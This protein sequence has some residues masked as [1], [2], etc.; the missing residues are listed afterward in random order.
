MPRGENHREVPAHEQEDDNPTQVE[1]DLNAEQLSKADSVAHARCYCTGHAADW[2]DRR[3]A[4][5]MLINSVMRLD[6]DD[7]DR[8]FLRAQ[9]QRRLRELEV[10]HVHTDD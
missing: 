2:L 5:S 8:P 10:E 6:L 3:M 9:L 4:R 7:Q 1:C